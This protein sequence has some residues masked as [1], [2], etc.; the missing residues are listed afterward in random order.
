MSPNTTD[1]LG[2][3]LCHGLLALGDC[4]TRCHRRAKGTDQVTVRE[5]QQQQ[6]AVMPKE[7]LESYGGQWVALRDGYVVANDLDPVALRDNP[8]VSQGDTLIPVPAQGSEL[9]LL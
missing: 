5:I 7:D 4:A 3:D 2:T 6:E 9:L 1:A 8:E